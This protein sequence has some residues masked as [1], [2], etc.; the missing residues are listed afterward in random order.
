[1]KQKQSDDIS[2][3][4]LI[5]MFLVLYNFFSYLI[6]SFMTLISGLMTILSCPLRIACFF[7]DIVLLGIFLVSNPFGNNRRNESCSSVNKTIMS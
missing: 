1:M 2:L 5:F 6:K 4:L 3:F 7:I